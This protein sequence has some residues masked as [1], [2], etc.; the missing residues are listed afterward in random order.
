MDRH[1]QRHGGIDKELRAIRKILN[2]GGRQLAHL[3]ELSK[4]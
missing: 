4:E 2:I 3:Q 1:A